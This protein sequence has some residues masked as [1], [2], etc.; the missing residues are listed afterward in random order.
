MK[1]L[2]ISEHH[3]PTVL[4]SLLT[5][6]ARQAASKISYTESTLDCMIKGLKKDI[7]YDPDIRDRRVAR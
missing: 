3:P 2:H 7:L 6:K 5:G 4:F 1:A